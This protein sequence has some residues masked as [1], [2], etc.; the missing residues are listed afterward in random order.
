MSYYYQ[1]CRKYHL[2]NLFLSEGATVYCVYCRV[3]VAAAVS[4]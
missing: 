3:T 4:L 1:C 2:H